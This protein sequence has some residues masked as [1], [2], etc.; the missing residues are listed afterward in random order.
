MN[1]I[2]AN[3]A[4]VF[5]TENNG[6][7]ATVMSH[8]TDHST[9]VSE[10]QVGASGLTACSIVPSPTPDCKSPSCLTWSSQCLADPSQCF[11]SH[12]T[13]TLLH[14]EYILHEYIG[15]YGVVHSP[16]MEVGMK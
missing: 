3:S 13:V 5:S 10:S 7:W 1:T 4:C 6:Q 8:G 9:V 11:T 16:Y 12:T 2:I 15:V 14:G